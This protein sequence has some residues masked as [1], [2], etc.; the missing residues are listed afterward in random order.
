MSYSQE[1]INQFSVT[2]LFEIVIIKYISEIQ[3]VYII[4][5]INKI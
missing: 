4:C 2:Y 3:Y 1:Q 5:T